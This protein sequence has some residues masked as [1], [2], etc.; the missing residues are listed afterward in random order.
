MWL[1]QLVKCLLCLWVHNMPQLCC[2][3]QWH[4]CWANRGQSCW[5]SL[6]EEQLREKLS[7]VLPGLWSPETRGRSC[8][9]SL[10]LQSFPWLWDVSLGFPAV[11]PAWES[12][13]CWTPKTFNGVGLIL[14]FGTAGFPD[15]E[16]AWLGCCHSFLVPGLSADL[17]LLHYFQ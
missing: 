10:A 16:A 11:V 5:K 8:G 14:A 13:K 15:H 4:L 9:S 6:P 1:E 7:T 2:Q 3:E 12:S 17:W